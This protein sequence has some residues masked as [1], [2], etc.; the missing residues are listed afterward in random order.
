ML[1]RQT[2]QLLLHVPKLAMLA[3]LQQGSPGE[4]ER[5]REFNLSIQQALAYEDMSML[6]SSA[7]VRERE[8]IQLVKY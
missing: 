7:K 8:R 5:E 3:R 2:L 1:H 4:R 6:E